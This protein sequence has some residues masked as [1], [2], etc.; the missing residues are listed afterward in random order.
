MTDGTP[1]CMVCSARAVRPDGLKGWAFLLCK[2]CG[3]H[4]FVC[5]SC[6]QAFG[7]VFKPKLGHVSDSKHSLY[8]QSRLF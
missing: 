3:A 2:E 1:S 6:W 4:N 5:A 8:T 7:K